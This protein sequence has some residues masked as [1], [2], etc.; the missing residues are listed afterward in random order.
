[1]HRQQFN[2]SATG[3]IM[4]ALRDKKEIKLSHMLYIYLRLY[5]SM[6]TVWGFIFKKKIL[7]AF[8][9]LVYCQFQA[10]SFKVNCNL[11]Q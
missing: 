7:S 1:M 4:M 6:P 11:L 2:F 5:S 10:F 9:N 3:I 8:R